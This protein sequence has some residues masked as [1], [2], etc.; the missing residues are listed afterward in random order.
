MGNVIT[1]T[2]KFYKLNAVEDKNE[3][4]FFFEA[5]HFLLKKQ[6]ISQ[7]EKERSL[8]VNYPNFQDFASG[9]FPRSMTINAFQKK[10]KTTI[11]VDYN[12]ITF[13]EDLSFPYSVPDGYDRISIKD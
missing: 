1:E 13:N 7:S 9:I 8:E 6:E 10:G 2:D 12:S 3:K 4:S 5:E 11:I